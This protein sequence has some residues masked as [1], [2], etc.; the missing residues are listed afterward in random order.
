[1]KNK[2]T[3]YVAH[4]CKNTTCNNIWVDEDL[5]NAKSYPPKWRYCEECCINYG[6]VN[7]ETPPK[8]ELSQ[9][10]LETLNKHKFAKRKNDLKTNVNNKIGNM[11]TME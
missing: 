8:K 2:Q 9:R 7:Q 3:K 5:T 6:Y 1:M 10:Q 4:I 11:E